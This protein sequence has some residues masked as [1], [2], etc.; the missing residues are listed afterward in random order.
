MRLQKYIMVIL[1]ISLIVVSLSN[2]QFSNFEKEKI[3]RIELI[4]KTKN[5]DYWKIVTMGAQ[6]AAKEFGVEMQVV[7]ASDENNINQQ[8][9]LV[10]EAINKKV[11]AII[12]ASNDYEELAMSVTNAE[13]NG[14]PVIVIDSA[15]KSKDI[16]SYIA[17]DNLKAGKM[18]AKQFINLCGK[19]SRVMLMNFVK[20]AS[21]AENREKGFYE[22]IKKY[23]K[24]QVIE[25]NY[26]YS[27]VETARII[28]KL[29]LSKYPDL[30]AV[31]ALNAPS[32]IGVANAVNE[33][34]LKGKIKVIGF[35][36]FPEEIDLV[37]EGTI[38]KLIVQ[39]P[40]AMGY[41]G[42]KNAVDH[43]NKKYVPK[44][45]ETNLIEIDIDNMYTKENQKL[46][47]PFVK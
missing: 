30:S 44:Y 33:A 25:K 47:F 17:T 20:G 14:I 5:S 9:S 16:V 36:N 46:V 34:K 27:D 2:S 13:E 19:D 37:E 39:N 18:L 7:G 43:L 12:L 29:S 26:C 3:K 42:V 10:E 32:T 45:I 8:K 6:A 22:E 24:I 23:P 21:S 4:L 11:D 31:V 38:Q 15:V 40:F 28:T 35:D 1:M 41:L